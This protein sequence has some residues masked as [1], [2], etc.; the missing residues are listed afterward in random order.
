M[1][2]K[3]DAQNPA[4]L[5][6]LVAGGTKLHAVPAT[7][8]WRPASTPPTRSTPRLSAKNAKF[9]KVYDHWKPFRAEEILWSRV[10]EG[11]FDSFMARMSAADKL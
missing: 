5:R 8:S 9:K 6:E 7:R 11:G 10:A 4:A 2:A 1:L 3:Y